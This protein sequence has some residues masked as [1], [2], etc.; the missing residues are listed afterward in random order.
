MDPMDWDR[1][2]A[3]DPAQVALPACRGGGWPESVD[4]APRWV[5][6]SGNG[7]YTCRRTSRTGWG[8]LPG[9]YT[10]IGC[11]STV[12]DRSTTMVEVW[13]AIDAAPIADPPCCTHEC[14]LHAPVT[15]PAW[16]T[17]LERWWKRIFSPLERHP[18][19]T[20]AAHGSCPLVLWSRRWWRGMDEE[21]LPVLIAMDEGVWVGYTRAELARISVSLLPRRR[22]WHFGPTWQW[23]SV[24]LAPLVEEASKL[25]PIVG[26][27]RREGGGLLVRLGQGDGMGW[28]ARWIN[29]AGPISGT[30]GPSSDGLAHAT[31]FFLFHVFLFLFFLFQFKP[32]FEFQIFIFRCTKQNSSMMHNLHTHI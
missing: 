15:L 30:G 23:Q 32:K 22:P 14:L 26:E 31:G 2:L 3:P 19:L 4:P 7:S 27:D 13:W 1:L 12:H 11:P 9:I 8:V 21:G 25:G 20:T 16:S 17:L 6:P 18:L 24:T 29:R 28:A 5:N 10:T